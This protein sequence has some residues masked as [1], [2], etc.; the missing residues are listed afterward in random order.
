MQKIIF[1]IIASLVFIYEIPYANEIDYKSCQSIDDVIERES[2]E[3]LNTEIGNHDELAWLYI[4]R[5][6]SYLLGA[7]YEKAIQD[8]LLADFHS[9]FMFNIDNIVMIGFRSAFG[10][11]VSYDN[12]D[13]Q[14]QVEEALQQLQIIAGHINCYR[15]TA[16]QACLG[17]TRFSMNGY[18]FQKTALDAGTQKN[19][20][21]GDILGPDTPPNPGWCE[22]VVTGVGR[23]MDAIACLA[24]S[25]GVKIALIGVI[26]ALI[27]RGVKCCQTGAFWKAC[28]AP[29]VRKWKEWKNNKE[30]H[31]LPNTGNLPLYLN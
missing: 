17:E 24:P 31:M 12:L 8:F 18:Y 23:A 28:A 11:A 22:E 9:S 4:S 10:K 3:I 13:I 26:E 20:N 1:F 6:E 30:K 14:E 29:I 5:G 21:Y 15:G 19:Q 25:Y 27:T 2:L 16:L 7:Q